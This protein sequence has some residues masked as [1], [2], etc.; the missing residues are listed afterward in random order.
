MVRKKKEGQMTITFDFEARALYVK[1]K[2]GK[3]AKTVEFSQETFVDLD[4]KGHLLGVEMLSPGKLT[5]H[6]KTRVLAPLR[7]I[8][9]KFHQPALK[10][11]FDNSRP[12]VHA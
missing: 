11:I 4:S 6:K 1:I 12:Y 9:T 2:D 5:I 8:A 7:K 3:I 10:N